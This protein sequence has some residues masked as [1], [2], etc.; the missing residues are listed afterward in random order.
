MKTKKKRPVK[1]FCGRTAILRKASEIKKGAGPNEYLYVCSAYPDCDSYVKAHQDTLKP[2]GTLANKQLRR[3]RILAHRSFDQIWKNNILSRNAAYE[4]LCSVV[5]LD[6]D[7]AHISLFGE[8]M[9][10]QVI[11]ECQKVLN[12]NRRKVS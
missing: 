9:C 7:Q 5:E 12:N 3:M 6:R 8:Y 4:W 11:A 10:A 1:C 2:M